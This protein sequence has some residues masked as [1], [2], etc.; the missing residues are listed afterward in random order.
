M[1]TPRLYD[2]LPGIYRFRDESDGGGLPLRALF[3]VFQTHYDDLEAEISRLYDDWFI[4]TCSTDMLPAFAE[5]LAMSDLVALQEGG[6]DVRALVANIVR[7]RQRKG[8]A[9]ALQDISRDATG[10]AVQV[11]DGLRSTAANIR[12][13]DKPFEG[14]VDVKKLS[15]TPDTPREPG[16]KS[17]DVRNTVAGLRA[18]SLN[19]WRIKAAFTSD[20][21]PD[22]SRIDGRRRTFSALGHDKVAMRPAHVIDESGDTLYAVPLTRKEARALLRQDPDSFCIQVRNDANELQP[23][24]I[25]D[26]SAWKPASV[27]KSAQTIYVDPEL[28]RMLT[29]DNITPYRVNCYIADY[30]GIGA[31]VPSRPW[32]GTFDVTI[33]VAPKGRVPNL[34]GFLGCETFSDALMIASRWTS[35]ATSARIV[36]VDSQT[37][38]AEAEGWTFAPL[39]SIRELAIESAPG[40][41]PTLDGSLRLTVQDDSTQILLRGL[42]VR[43][44]IICDPNVRCSL[45][46]VTLFAPF[47]PAGETSY[48][49]DAQSGQSGTVTTISIK[50]SIVG[51]ASR[52]SGQ[53]ALSMEESIVMGAVE[54]ARPEAL[55]NLTARTSTFLGNV[56]ADVITASDS[57]FD[58]QVCAHSPHL[59]YVRYCVVRPASRAPV[60]YRCVQT[61]RPLLESTS[62]GRLSFVRLRTDVPDEVRTG[63]SNRSEIG[64]FNRYAQGQRAANLDRIAKEFVPE[65]VGFHVVYRS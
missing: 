34:E 43:G 53:A 64:A 61:D 50:Q 47:A 32:G 38:A 11:V 23:L 19:V 26:L 2:L 49:I 56:E 9:V 8:T 62:Y 39:G 42:N 33:L 59:G 30:H 27:A 28:G 36:L 4:E 51:G 29:P 48:A 55:F 12:V 45:E 37:Y 35:G 15:R 65:G 22:R 40:A 52:W 6:A 41:R 63:A 54:C 24:E 7:Y 13:D 17:V 44:T 1:S 60:R 16:R 25:A 10:W 46:R 14:Y 58:R 57:L 5:L 3:A 18:V 21:E 20:V 31:G